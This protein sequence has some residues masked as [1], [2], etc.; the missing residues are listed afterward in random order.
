MW[1]FV[2]HVPTV[3]CW[4]S[5]V[6]PR[7][8]SRI[9]FRGESSPLLVG[10]Y[11]RSTVAAKATIVMAPPMMPD[12]KGYFLRSGRPQML[13]DAGYDVFLFDYGGFGESEPGRFDWP[14]DIV[15]AGHLALQLNPL[16]PVVLF[17]LSLGAGFGVCAL[18]TPGHPFNV[19]ILESPFAHPHDYLRSRPLERW[20][21]RLLS[22]LF[23]RRIRNAT[24]ICRAPTVKGLE[25]VMFIYC[26][27]DSISPP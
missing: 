24:P 20:A 1:P 7:G 4:P 6:D 15:S 22:P 19:A 9:E 11:R 17:G 18:D 27:G 2:G 3:W 16:Q 21:V 13:L 8:W 12:A 23:R 26:E 14:N 25:G 10:L 5:E